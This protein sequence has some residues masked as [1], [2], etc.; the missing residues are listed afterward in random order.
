M[1]KTIKISDETRG[2]WERVKNKTLGKKYDLSIVASDD[3]LMKKLNKEYRKKDKTTNVLSFPLSEDTGEIFINIPLAKKEA[4]DCG[5]TI[6][7]YLD[8]L[9]IHSLLHLNG[10]DHGE[11]M[12]REEEKLLKTL[13]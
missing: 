4:K 12:E 10:Y 11:K 2:R 6:K 3:K 9:F 7:K 8:F 5:S 13:K 1:I